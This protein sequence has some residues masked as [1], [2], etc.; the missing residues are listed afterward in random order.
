MQRGISN[1]LGTLSIIYKDLETQDERLLWRV[2][3]DQ[4]DAWKFGSV[5][6]DFTSFLYK[7]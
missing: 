6:F 4:G 5:T 1:H 2:E 7:V 3:G